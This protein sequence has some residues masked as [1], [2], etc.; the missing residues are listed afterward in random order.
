MMWRII[1]SCF[2]FD[3]IEEPD[4]EEIENLELDQQEVN[5]NFDAEFVRTLRKFIL[6]GR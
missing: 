2:R 5:K 6:S 1:S 4:D 3:E